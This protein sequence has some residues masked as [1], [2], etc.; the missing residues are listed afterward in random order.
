ME[1]HLK[2]WRK[3]KKKLDMIEKIRYNLGRVT[4]SLDIFG[5]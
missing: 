1:K 3:V 5:V 2:K 4:R